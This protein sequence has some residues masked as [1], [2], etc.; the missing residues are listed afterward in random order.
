[1]EN[2]RIGRRSAICALLLF[3]LLLAL[4]LPRYA[5]ADGEPVTDTNGVGYASLEEAIGK[6][7]GPFRVVG[8]TAACTIPSGAT[9]EIT[10]GK[11]NGSFFNS[12]ALTGATDAN[13]GT[14]YDYTNTVI[15]GTV[16]VQGSGVS[17]ASEVRF[18]S[19][20]SESADYQN[21]ILWI[22][23]G[24]SIQYLIINDYVCTPDGGKIQYSITYLYNN[25]A[26]SAMKLDAKKYPATYCVMTVD[27]TIPEAPDT[28][29][30]YVFAGWYCK[31]LGYEETNLVKTLTIPANRGAN[32]T[33]L[34]WW[35]K[36]PGHNEGKQGASSGMAGG[37]S[38][39]GSGGVT[40]AMSAAAGLLSTD[41]EDEDDE[42]TALVDYSA[43]QGGGM[44]V[45]NA[46]STTR[47][48][49]DNA[50]GDITARANARTQR[51]FPWQWIGVGLGGALI[52]FAAGVTVRRRLNERNEATLEKLNIHD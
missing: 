11:I 4:G 38:G 33:L 43:S 51:R 25:T 42:D 3:A 17:G 1:M 24:Q 35:T 18:Y 52:L 26:Q 22:P 9:V 45:R 28:E 23:R 14:I 8:E 34:S 5:R 37:M 31:I 29:V 16:R 50:S 21:G 19:G 7:V 47:H 30:D 32:L 2:Q 20:A 48:T 12:G 44:R 27:Q 13:C 41:D 39:G 49:F 40:G 36:S 10:T 46:S 6:G 15:S